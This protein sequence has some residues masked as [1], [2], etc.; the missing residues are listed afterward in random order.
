MDD[1]TLA[2]VEAALD[3]LCGMVSADGEREAVDIVL[4]AGRT[5]LAELR[6]TRA[7]LAA[8]RDVERWFDDRAL[9]AEEVGEGAA[10]V[11]DVWRTAQFTL[12]D[13]LGATDQT[14]HQR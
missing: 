2:K 13:A 14:G 12:A 10:N 5:M 11:A 3:D 8:V 4:E 7:H 6:S 1:A 9:Y